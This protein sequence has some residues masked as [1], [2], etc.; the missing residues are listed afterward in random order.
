MQAFS[1]ATTEPN[2]VVSQGTPPSPIANRDPSARRNLSPPALPCQ[3]GRRLGTRTVRGCTSARPLALGS[4]CARYDVAKQFRW[5]SLRHRNGAPLRTDFLCYTGSRRAVRRR[6][7]LPP[8]PTPAVLVLGVLAAR[9]ASIFFGPACDWR[10]RVV[11]LDASL[12]RRHR[13]GVRFA[14]AAF[15]LQQRRKARKRAE[16]PSDFSQST[17]RESPVSPVTPVN[18]RFPFRSPHDIFAIAGE[19]SCPSIK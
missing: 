3:F 14:M 11:V 9:L 8:I 10:K 7:V 5:K 12:D 17:S 2:F 19:P 18:F 16:R 6:R 15:L 4:S 13:K 1:N